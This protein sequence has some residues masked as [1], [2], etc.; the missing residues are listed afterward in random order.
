MK[1]RPS[2]YSIASQFG[3][4][5]WLI[6]RA[7]LP[8]TPASITLPSASSNSSVWQGS[9]GSLGGR[10][11]ATSQLER[12]PRYST[13]RAPFLIVRVANAPRPCV[14]DDRTVY[15][16]LARPGAILSVG[17]SIRRR[18]GTSAA[19][20]GPAVSQ[21]EPGDRLQF[22]VTIRCY[23][24]LVTECGKSVLATVALPQ[25]REHRAH[26][27]VVV[28]G[29]PGRGNE[30][31]DRRRPRGQQD[32]A[33]LRGPR[34]RHRLGRSRAGLRNTVL[35]VKRHRV[36][37]ARG[38]HLDVGRAELLVAQHR[39]QHCCGDRIRIGT[40]D[41]LALQIIELGVRLILVD[42]QKYRV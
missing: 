17:R 33:T 32:L 29:Q 20:R 2:S 41:R 21:A 3:S 22:V 26:F 14:G 4:Q 34:L 8:R 9:E 30:L 36:L 38:D 11:Q 40:D 18:R 7:A 6:Q 10:S 25:R 24:S 23:E 35:D 15:G 31:L 12:A 13:M 5:P 39:P 27:L 19:A 16:R 42:Q 28:G 37:V 1:T